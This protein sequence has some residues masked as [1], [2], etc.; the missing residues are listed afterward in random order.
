ME[1]KRSTGVT[2]LVV[3]YC[4][5]WVMHLYAN[6]SAEQIQYGDYRDSTMLYEYL[7]IIVLP[8]LAFG[9]FYL[10]ELFRKTAV[11]YE[12]FNII[13]VSLLLVAG[14]MDSNQYSINKYLA[15]AAIFLF[16][17]CV[18][19]AIIYFLTRPKVKEQF[20]KEPV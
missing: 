17:L 12:I 9:I 15:L 3:I 20:K 19:L 6:F 8:I 14:F 1:K 5:T 4:I 11:I 13:A 7:A 2:V 18:P 16:A 10:K